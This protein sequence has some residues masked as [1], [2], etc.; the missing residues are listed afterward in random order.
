M[1]FVSDICKFSQEAWE[2]T[3]D[4]TGFHPAVREARERMNG[5]KKLIDN[6]Q[7]KVAMLH[8]DCVSA[9]TPGLMEAVLD[10]AKASAMDADE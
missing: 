5:R 10:G 6:L 2:E 1:P 8:Y 4:P 7:I 3:P 9:H